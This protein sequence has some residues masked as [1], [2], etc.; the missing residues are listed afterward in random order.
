MGRYSSQDSAALLSALGD[1]AISQTQYLY[2]APV[3][4]QMPVFG[5]GLY[6]IFS[7]PGTYSWT[8]PANIESIRVRVIGAGGAGGTPPST[9]GGD[10]GTSSFGAL[11][12][13]TGGAGGRCNG[14]TASGGT[15]VGGD[16]QSRGGDGLGGSLGGYGNRGGG[17]GAGSQLGD[18]GHGRIGGGGIIHDGG[19][20]LRGGGSPYG[21]DGGPD[22]LG[23][24]ADG[25]AI[26]NPIALRLRFPFDGFPGGGGMPTADNGGG[27]GG[28]GGGGAGGGGNGGI[29]G[30]AGVGA[31]TTDL[32]G[33]VGGIGGGGGGLYVAGT[34]TAS[35]GGGGGYAHGQFGVYPGQIFVV[36]VGAGGTSDTT[37]NGGPG[38]VVV[39]W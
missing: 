35:G 29:G 5:N 10:G 17:G 20:I 33:G 34:G 19:E 25:T 21:S 12:S 1:I 39:E 28:I 24:Y 4:G 38:L 37:G 23:T 8:V 13:A 2:S 36:T 26:A 30:G 3:A 15:G 16:F 31:N 22:I 7:I 11:I 32:R 27:D 18:G 9:I 14:Q 6:R